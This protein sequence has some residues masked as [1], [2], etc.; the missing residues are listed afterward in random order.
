MSVL[1][2]DGTMD[3]LLTAVARGVEFP[4][5][6]IEI[7]ASTGR[8]PSLFEKAEPV[9]AE[10]ERARRLLRELAQC[11]SR[12]IVRRL[13]HAAMSEEPDIGTALAGYVREV[14]RRGAE[15]D[16]FLAH[17]D[18][19][20]VHEVARAVGHELH[21]LKG[22]VR[23]RRMQDDTLWGPISPDY[24]VVLPLGL[25]FRG[26]MPSEA[27]IVHDVRRRLA[28][29]WDRRRLEWV[30]PG[31]VPPEQPALAEDES[32]YQRLWQTYFR[33]IAV[34][35]RRNPRL[36]HQFMPVRYWRHLVENPGAR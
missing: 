36:Q 22:L 11:G 32:A 30:D 4:A 20:R 28:V 23:F 34:R 17:P 35:E 25:Y 12:P 13:L 18:V 16:G 21:R 8:Q 31:D 5:E 7:H 6:S 29:R 19:A 15:A 24:N 9:A 1:L 33:T 3:G 27:W 26:R 2:H 10:P 14:R